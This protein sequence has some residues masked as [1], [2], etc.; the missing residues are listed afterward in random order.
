MSFHLS[1]PILILCLVAA[2]TGVAVESRSA[3]VRHDLTV[4]VFSDDEAA[5]FRQSARDGS[6]SLIDQFTQRT[7]K[8]VSVDLVAQRALDA[9]LLSL[10]MSDS[11]QAAVP[12]LVEIDLASI[13][14]Y[15]R[16]P[17]ADIALLPLNE[18]LSRS[19]RLNRIIPS[20]L[21]T[22][23]KGGLVFG[24]P[25]DVH[26]VTLTYRKDL[27]D[28]AGVDLESPHTWEQFQEACLS[29]QAYWASHGEPARKAVELYAT[30]SEELLLM[31]LQ[32][33]VNLIDDHN[34]IHIADAIVT[35][36]VAFYAQLVAGDNRITTDT[37]PGTPLAYRD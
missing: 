24:I 9:R 5:T 4:W 22:W 27:F 21:A 18:F 32:R 35:Q 14:K 37:L 8:T 36:T 11:R 29:Y 3:A 31:L 17:P 30:Q 2:V 7:H 33:H 12:D 26:P 34:Q 28:Q 20:R 13:G 25:R 15:F 6:P 16:P 10:F 1:Y 23:S 19:G